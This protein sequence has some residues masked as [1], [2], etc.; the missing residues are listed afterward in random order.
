MDENATLLRPDVPFLDDRVARAKFS[1]ADD[2]YASQHLFAPRR[3]LIQPPSFPHLV[4]KFADRMGNIRAGVRLQLR[5]YDFLPPS[6]VFLNAEG[7]AH[8]DMTLGVLLRPYEQSHV[9]PALQ[10]GQMLVADN[11]GYLPGGHPF[12]LQPFLCVRGV[13]EYHTHPQHAETMWESIR[14][15]PAFGLQYVIEQAHAVFRRDLF[16]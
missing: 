5:N 3:W 11:G 1:A 13:W 14:D 12:T 16:E 10:S 2:L 8:S 7:V 15:D 9:P 4:V 6:V